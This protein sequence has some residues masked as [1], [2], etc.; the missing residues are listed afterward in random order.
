MFCEEFLKKCVGGTSE[1]RI[2][3]WMSDVA[4]SA[5]CEHQSVVAPWN[6][7]FLT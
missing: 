6:V 2:S 7:A 3:R 4:E 5:G 1:I